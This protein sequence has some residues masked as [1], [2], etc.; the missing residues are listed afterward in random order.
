VLY[1]GITPPTFSE[2]IPVTIV[3][4]ETGNDV[5]D[6]VFKCGIQYKPATDLDVAMFDVALAFDG[7]VDESTIKTTNSSAKT[8]NF[9]FADF[10]QGHLGKQVSQ[11][12]HFRHNFRRNIT[13]ALLLLLADKF[14]SPHS[15]C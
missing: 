14:A 5:V 9:N 2:P 11:T 15:Q 7:V 13:G 10:P 3:C 4:N 6:F 12:L 1:P 8:I